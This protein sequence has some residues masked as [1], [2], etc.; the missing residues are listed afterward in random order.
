MKKIIYVFVIF[1][2][3]ISISDSKAETP[4]QYVCVDMPYYMEQDSQGNFSG[5]L[6]DI[7]NKTALKAGYSNTV[8]R[9]EPASRMVDSIIQGRAHVWNGIVLPVL[10]DHVLVGDTPIALVT[11][12]VF[13]SKGTSPLNQINELK[14]DSII[15]IRGYSYGGLTRKLKEQQGITLLETESHQSA[16]KMLE[17]KRAKYLLDYLEPVNNLNVLSKYPNISFSAIDTFESYFAVSK[18]APNAPEIMKRFNKAYQE[19]LQSNQVPKIKDHRNK[20]R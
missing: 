12:G 2:A 14:N 16:F 11:L 18:K 15:T 7:F 4:L 13:Y 1:I 19:L 17:A 9:M 3:T 5:I 6:V 10:K 8:L 20:P